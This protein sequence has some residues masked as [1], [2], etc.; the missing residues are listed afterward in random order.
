MNKYIRELVL[1][2]LIALPYVYL[3]SIWKELPEQVPT[4]F[5]LAGKANDW[6]GK[7]TLLYIPGAMCLGTY[8]LMLVIPVLDPK[9]KLRQ[10]EGKYQGLRFMLTLFM[11]GLSVYLLYISKQGGMEN[12][13]WLIAFIGLMLAMMGNYFQALRPNYF[14]GIRTPWTLESE[15]VWKKTHWLGGRL[16]MA[17]GVLIII[18]SFI[19]RNHM[20]LLIVAGSILFI[21]VV[22]PV[23]FSFIAFRKESSAQ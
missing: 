1:W 19:I 22:V 18:L 21:L 3:A 23:G 17:G 12:P 7:H 4:H 15:D 8:L 6:S 9:R 16:W 5:D 10:M 14:V 13:Q 2:V 11:S 20:P